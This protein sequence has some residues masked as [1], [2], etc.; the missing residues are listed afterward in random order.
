[1]CISQVPV[2]RKMRAYEYERAS[3][4]FSSILYIHIPLHQVND[5]HIQVYPFPIT[6]NLV[7]ILFMN[8]LRS[9]R[10]KYMLWCGFLM[11]ILLHTY[12]RPAQFNKER[13]KKERKT[14]DMEHRD[15]AKVASSV[16]SHYLFSR[17]GQY[18]IAF[19]WGHYFKSQWGQYLSLFRWGQYF[20]FQRSQYLFFQPGQNFIVRQSHYFN[21]I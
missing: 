12:Q 7:Q 13:R 17:P 1:M 20:I 18:F 6:V 2:L 3:A 5:T 16:P 8:C 11:C 15:P 10:I 9:N 14:E 4:R 21:P 19:L